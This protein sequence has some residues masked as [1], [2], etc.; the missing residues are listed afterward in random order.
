MIN[1]QKIEAKATKL[2]VLNGLYKVPVDIF[3]LIERLNLD[4]EILP[5]EDEMS[6]FIKIEGSHANIVIN[7]Q[8][9]LKRQRFTAAHEVGH[10]V[11]H[12]DVHQEQQI[13]IDD[14]EAGT[15][16]IIDSRNKKARKVFNRD[17]SSEDGTHR[18]DIEANRFAAALLM[19][20]E[21]I[22]NVVV[23]LNIN[24]SNEFDTKR[25]ADK[26]NVSVQAMILRLANIGVRHF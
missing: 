9:D 11:L 24:L 8:H 23:R 13:F 12:R 19:P 25:L 18:L 5:M 26:F 17:V 15:R 10:Y 4:L 3:T 20:E 21:L 6:G 14:N 2:L 1:N 16:S 22:E 7:K